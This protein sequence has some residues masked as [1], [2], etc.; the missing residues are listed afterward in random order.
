MNSY[1][2]HDKAEVVS[3]IDN[4]E[5]CRERSEH[6]STYN[7]LK[8]SATVTIDLFVPSDRIMRCLGRLAKDF[9]HGWPEAGT[10]LFGLGEVVKTV[11]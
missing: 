4:C 2:W 5:P 3:Q 9:P 1:F 8:N 7:K 11:E 10:V 6:G